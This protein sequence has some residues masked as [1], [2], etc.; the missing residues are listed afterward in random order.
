VRIVV[1]QDPLV[2]DTRDGRLMASTMFMA[3]RQ[4]TGGVQPRWCRGDECTRLARLAT[5]RSVLRIDSPA[6]LSH[7]IGIVVPPPPGWV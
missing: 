2:K 5:G 4:E 6:G 1:Y 7:V 3:V